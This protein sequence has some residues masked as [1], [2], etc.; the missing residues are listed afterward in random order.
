ML[1]GIRAICSTNSSR[2]GLAREIRAHPEIESLIR[3]SDAKG[4]FST[5]NSYQISDEFTGGEHSVSLAPQQNRVFKSTHPNKFGFSIDTEM[6]QPSGWKA[7]PRITTGLCDATPTEYLSRLDRQNELFDDNILIIGVIRYP[8]GIS[9]LTS[10]P[11]YVGERTEQH[12]IDPWFHHRGWLPIP[13][14]DGAFYHPTL[15]LAIMDALPRNVLTLENG[16]LMPFDVVIAKPP[17][18]LKWQ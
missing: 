16:S 5:E 12:L 11:F 1:Q 4:L 9:I 15:N 3:W 13:G 6:I 18:G 8:S 10:Q 14:K 17:S 7:K 2:L